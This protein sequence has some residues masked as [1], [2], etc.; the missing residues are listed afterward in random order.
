MKNNVKTNTELFINYNQDPDIYIKDLGVW[1]VA[2]LIILGLAFS[3]NQPIHL[4]TIRKLLKQWGFS[5]QDLD[6]IENV[7]K[8]EGWILKNDKGRKK[9]TVSPNLCKLFSNA[10]HFFNENLLMQINELYTIIDNSFHQHGYRKNVNRKKLVSEIGID[11]LIYLA[12]ADFERQVWL[13]EYLAS[14]LRGKRKHIYRHLYIALPPREYYPHKAMTLLKKKQKNICRQSIIE[15]EGEFW[16]ANLSDLMKILHDDRNH[17]DII[18]SGFPR[19]SIFTIRKELNQSF[20]RYSY[21][22]H[23]IKAKKY[24]NS[25]GIVTYETYNSPDGNK[26]PNDSNS[27]IRVVFFGEANGNRMTLNDCD[28]IIDLADE[29][30]VLT[31][32]V[33]NSKNNFSN[34]EVKKSIKRCPKNSYPNRSRA[35]GHYGIFSLRER[36]IACQYA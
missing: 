9:Y 7:L 21:E 26:F 8:G 4:Y 2:T 28:K 1:Q 32:D 27:P 20:V 6:Y 22:F 33:V 29:I 30:F 3:K 18:T 31:P 25:N 14:Q 24:P 11:L 34:H 17:I 19:Q 15:V 36:T 23:Y 35:P 10:S 16:K 5:N 12:D 13:A